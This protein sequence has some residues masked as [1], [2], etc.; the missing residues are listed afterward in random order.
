MTSW[1]MAHEAG[2]DDEEMVHQLA[3]LL[4]AGAEPLRNLIGN[5]LHRLLTHDRYATRAV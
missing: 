4:G 5:T 2:L 1:L 3:L